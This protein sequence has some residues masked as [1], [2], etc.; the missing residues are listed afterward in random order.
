MVGSDQWFRLLDLTTGAFSEPIAQRYSGSSAMWRQADG[1]YLCACMSR[2]LSTAG[3]QTYDE[4]DLHL[5]TFA[6]DGAAI[7]D[8]P[9][10]TFTRLRAALP[11]ESD[12]RI[13][14]LAARSPD[15]RTIY[16]GEAKDEDG[17]WSFAIH[18]I[19]VISARF[20]GSV[21]VGTR[22][23]A[24][25][26]DAAV[27]RP[28][29]SP[30]GARVM[31]VLATYGPDGGL[32]TRVEVQADGL[33]VSPGPSS[34][35]ALPYEGWAGV[36]RYYLSCQDN[37]LSLYGADGAPVGSLLVPGIGAGG[38]AVTNGPRADVARGRLLYWDPFVHRLVVV[39][40]VR[41]SV[42]ASVDAPAPVARVAGVDAALRALAGW[43]AP[44][45]AAK[46]LL[47]P[48]T[49]L[50]SDGSRFFALGVTGPGIEIAGGSAGIYVF[51]LAAAPRYVATWAP[52]ADLYGLRLSVDGSV[53]YASG[54][55]GAEADGTPNRQKPASLAAYDA[56]T[57]EVRLILGALDGQPDLWLSGTGL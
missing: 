53:L 24:P 22:H 6:A 18:A 55:A 20:I 42:V 29:V 50:S 52:T 33:A 12:P 16:V 25:S 2:G 7:A 4:I 43:I 47:Q 28:I 54:M 44:S 17:D 40:A 21:T 30:D 37:A 19:D 10:R 3:S 26:I 49:A 48:P 34:A 41:A 56:V 35:C 38:V 39:D 11:A 32:S 45:V 46:T 51:D 36:D 15:G 14:L 9:V 23:D 5:K 31:V 13:E 1:S 57:G 27:A 8:K